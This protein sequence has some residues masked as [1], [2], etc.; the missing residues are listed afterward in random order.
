MPAGKGV[1]LAVSVTS[2][3]QQQHRAGSANG[4]RQSNVLQEREIGDK[5]VQ[6]AVK[7]TEGTASGFRSLL[8]SLSTSKYARRRSAAVPPLPPGVR[9]PGKLIKDMGPVRVE[10]KVWLANQRTF[11]KWC[12][13]SILLSSL[14]LGLFNAAGPTNTVARVLAVIYTLVAIFAG[15]WGWWVFHMRSHMIQQRSGKDFDYVLGPVIVCVGLVVA[16]CLNFGFKVG[17]LCQDIIHMVLDIANRYLVSRGD[18]QSWRTSAREQHGRS[19]K[20]I[21]VFLLSDAFRLSKTL[22]CDG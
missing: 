9:E 8:P 7:T 16:L 20:T 17:A 14:S 4:H 6:D 11:V 10:P 15:A 19:G 22:D 2:D 1:H 12:H 5:E 18:S 13:V 21:H 3:G